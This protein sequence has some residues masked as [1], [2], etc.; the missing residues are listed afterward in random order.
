MTQFSNLH[1]NSRKK[2]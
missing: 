1:V 2:D